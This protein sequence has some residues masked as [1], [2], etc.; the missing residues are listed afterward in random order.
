MPTERRNLSSLEGFFK[1][2]NGYPPAPTV[3]KEWLE[4]VRDSWL[5]AEDWMP[6][7]GVMYVQLLE[8]YR[9]IPE[10]AD[11]L[12]RYADRETKPK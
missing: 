10:I 6:R 1:P 12:K 4:K 11:I 2:Y 8:P 5:S 3:S 7:E 9:D